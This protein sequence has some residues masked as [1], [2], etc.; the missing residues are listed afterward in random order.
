MADV[1]PAG[2]LDVGSPETVGQKIVANL[3]ALEAQRVL[4]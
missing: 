4:Y 3:R 1:G 2:P